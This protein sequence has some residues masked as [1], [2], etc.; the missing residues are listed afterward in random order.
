MANDALV[1]PVS[2][3]PAISSLVQTDLDEQLY[4]GKLWSRNVLL[5]LL[6]GVNGFKSA[7][8]GIGTPRVEGINPKPN[9]MFVSGLTSE[10]ARSLTTIGS[11]VFQP[12]VKL[13]PIDPNITRHT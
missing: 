7:Y 6:A 8:Y 1:L 2:T 11:D 3:R 9:E 12:L 10:R 4:E 5:M 13:R